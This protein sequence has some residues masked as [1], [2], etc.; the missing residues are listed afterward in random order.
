MPPAVMSAGRLFAALLPIKLWP[1]MRG[2]EPPIGSVHPADDIVLPGS[3]AIVHMHSLTRRFNSRRPKGPEQFETARVADQ[4]A[5]ASVATN[6]CPMAHNG[7]VLQ[8]ATDCVTSRDVTRRIAPDP[9]EAHSERLVSSPARVELF[10]TAV[11]GVFGGRDI[12]DRGGRAPGVP[13]VDPRRCCQRRPRR[14]GRLQRDCFHLR[15]SGC[16]GL[17]QVSLDKRLHA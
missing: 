8:T 16:H 17:S 5:Y 13:P 2:A 14:G 6:N 3:P 9:V 12:P 4:S 11:T 7:R 1:G 15:I 10:A